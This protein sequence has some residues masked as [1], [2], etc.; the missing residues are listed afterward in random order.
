MKIKAFIIFTLLLFIYGC[1]DIESEIEQANR[2]AK[3]YHLNIKTDNPKQ[4]YSKDFTEEEGSL[5]NV[6]VTITSLDSAPETLDGIESALRVYP[7]GF[8]SEVIDTIY[9][10]GSITIEG[11]AAGGTYGSRWIALSNVAQW[12]GTKANYENAH[13]G[14]HHELSSLIFNNSPFSVMT[15]QSLLSRDWKPAKSNFEALTKDEL[16]PD[17]SAG[18]LSD[19]GKTSMGN[20]FNTYAEFAFAEPE[21]LRELAA[22]YPVIANKLSVFITA[23]TQIFPE[24]QQGFEEYFTNTGLSDVAIKPDNVEITIHSDFSNIKPQIIH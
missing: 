22:T 24:Y 7:E 20:D 16:A 4:S 18:F 12:N 1:L 14:V 23:Y 8:I 3:T 2:L 5:A 19:Y 15:W 13:R 9:I 11:A 6:E 21:K 17:Y 10:A